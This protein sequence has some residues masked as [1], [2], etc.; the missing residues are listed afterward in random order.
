MSTAQN[1]NIILTDDHVIVRNGLKELIQKLGPYTIVAE[2]DN[3]KHLI[4]DY[5]FK[6]TPDLL[7]LDH[8]MPEMNGTAVIEWFSRQR[9][10]IP[11]LLL[12]LT[13][14]ESLIVKLF[15]MGIR[16]YL[17]KNCSSSELK[18]A[19]QDIFHSG[20]YHDDMLTKALLGQ[21]QDNTEGHT[22]I[23]EKLTDRELEFLRLV[24]D[25]KEYTYEQIAGMM[26]A[27]RRTIDKYREGIFEKFGVKSKTGLVLYAVKHDLVKL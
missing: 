21:S 13:E 1:K 4:D 7:I 16:G 17:H 27:H 22:Q 25:E 24:C 18:Q 11:I 2:Y 5:P 15:R 8:E 3:G 14:D 19:L 9:I 12:T 10:Q 26:H 20:Y 6:V 23:M